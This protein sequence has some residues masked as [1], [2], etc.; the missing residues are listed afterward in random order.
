MI[1]AIE[2]IREQQDSQPAVYR[3]L[4]GNHQASGATPGQALDALEGLPE[5]QDEGPNEVTLVILQ[6]FRPDAF[7][8]VEQQA[9]LQQL[10]GRW[11]EAR[12][13]GETLLPAEQAELEWLAQVEW[14]AAS[15]R[16][17]ALL[18]QAPVPRLA[19][20]PVDAPLPSAA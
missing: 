5:A 17:R 9:R 10:M 1:A 8:G 2:I 15:Q 11:R 16:A 12:D 14:R 3:A 20:P 6:R 13:R 19:S 4:W 18:R 7:F